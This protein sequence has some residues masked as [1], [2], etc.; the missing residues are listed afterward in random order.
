MCLFERGAQGL[1]V[2]AVPFCSA[3]ICAVRARTRVLSVS[4][5]T[6]GVGRGR[7]WSRSRSIRPRR[8]GWA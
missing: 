5:S 1:D 8:S 7:A 4:G 6:A 3:L 2:F